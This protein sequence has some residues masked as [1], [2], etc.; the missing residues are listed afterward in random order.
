MARQERALV[1]FKPDVADPFSMNE[2]RGKLSFT[3]IKLEVESSTIP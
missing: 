1:N 3:S 2:L